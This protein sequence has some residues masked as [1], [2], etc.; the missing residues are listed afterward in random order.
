M[1]LAL[2]AGTP[3]VALS[4]QQ[5]DPELETALVPV[6]VTKADVGTQ[7]S[8]ACTFTIRYPGHIDQDVTWRR[9]VCAN[10][11]TRFLNGAVIEAVGLRDKLDA[12]SREDFDRLADTGI[13][14]V[15]SRFTASLFPLNV[16]GIIYEVPVRD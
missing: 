3:A 7:D 16:A 8:P 1:A 6:I 12:E 15:E 11:E 2:P 9:E 10:V 4:Q 5:I 13:L 14:Y